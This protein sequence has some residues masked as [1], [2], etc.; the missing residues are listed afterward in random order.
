ML[1]IK[2]VVNL[3]ATVDLRHGIC[4]WGIS[5]G[6]TSHG[7]AALLAVWDQPLGRP[8]YIHDATLL[9]RHPPALP[10][11]VPGEQSSL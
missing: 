6:A 10:F 1:R 8:G 2:K 11:D 7:A 5:L 9:K 4:L 3:G